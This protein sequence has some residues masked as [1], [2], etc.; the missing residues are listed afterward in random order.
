MTAS[1]AQV[2]ADG[3]AGAFAERNESLTVTLAMD[4]DAVAVKVYVCK[5]EIGDLGEPGAGVEEEPNDCHIAPVAVALP[6]ARIEQSG[7]Y[8][9]GHDW[10]KLVWC[11]WLA[12]LLHG[13]AAYLLALEEIVEELLDAFVLVEGCRG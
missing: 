1:G 9:V 11:V 13:M 3:L 10:C 7:E 6:A 8:V 5:F 2:A 4:Q 12:E